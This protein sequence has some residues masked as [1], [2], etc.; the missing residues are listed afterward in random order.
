MLNKRYAI[1]NQKKFSSFTKHNEILKKQIVESTDRKEQLKNA[2][3]KH[4]MFS[5]STINA[6]LI[7]T[8]TDIHST[9]SCPLLALMP[10][11]V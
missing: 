9:I 1:F 2:F 5:V 6:I 7:L 3:Q 4:Q 11:S 8:R 10:L